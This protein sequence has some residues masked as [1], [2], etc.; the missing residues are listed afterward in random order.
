MKATKLIHDCR[1]LDHLFPDE[2][3]EDEALVVVEGP[4]RCPECGQRW[5]VRLRQDA[6]EAWRLGHASRKW[7]RAQAAKLLT[8]RTETNA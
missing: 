4:W 1:P 5:K 8:E 3:L 6:A 7:R 2:R